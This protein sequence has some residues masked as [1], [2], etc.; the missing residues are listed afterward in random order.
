MSRKA[1]GKGRGRG[2]SPEEMKKLNT[3]LEPPGLVSA[4]E[5][6]AGTQKRLIVGLPAPRRPSR[7]PVS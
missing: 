1:Q 6:A 7:R 4:D 5:K 2:L 3:G